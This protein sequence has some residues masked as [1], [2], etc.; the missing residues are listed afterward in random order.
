MFLTA[1]PEDI[2]KLNKTSSA[3]AL[4][5]AAIIL[6]VSTPCLAQEARAT[7]SGTITDPSG[8]SIIGAQVRITNLETG[9]ALSAQSNEVG[10][11]RLLF[12]NPGAYRLS[13][14]MAGFRTFVREGIQLTLGQAATLDVPLQVGA[15]SETVTVAATAPLLEAEKADR[16]LVVDQRNLSELPVLARVPI[17][18]A[19]LTPGVIW[20]APNFNSLA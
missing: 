9:I 2:M 7:L 5:L 3:A 6:T 20:T 18:M 1:W 16:G 14:E 17:L 19:T 15:Q 8:S 4:A 10:Q 11:Y 13:V 12:I